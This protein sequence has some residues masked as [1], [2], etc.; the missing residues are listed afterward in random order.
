VGKNLAGVID[1]KN[2]AIKGKYT[3]NKK[4]KFL[5]KRMP[6]YRSMW[7]RRF[8]IYCDRSENILEW[9]SES[10]HIPYISPKDDRWHNYYPDFYIKYINKNNQIIK[11]LIEIKPHFQKKWDIN[12]AKWVACQKHCNKQNIEFKVLTEK[13]LF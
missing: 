5:G 13:E 3:P 8:M 6:V 7:E 2:V 10:V 12:V 4:E 9:D 11:A 1:M